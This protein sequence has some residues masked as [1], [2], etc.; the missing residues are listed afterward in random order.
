MFEDDFSA[1]IARA[2]VAVFDSHLKVPYCIYRRCREWRLI[3]M[4]LGRGFVIQIHEQVDTALGIEHSRVDSRNA[5]HSLERSLL[6]LKVW[7][8][9]TYEERE[10][11]IS[12][13]NIQEVTDST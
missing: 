2:L 3:I 1:G 12:V 8:K 9:W 10:A 11:R 7:R 13:Q 6:K 5:S 4:H